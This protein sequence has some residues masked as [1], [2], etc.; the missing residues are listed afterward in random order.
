MTT[1]VKLEKHFSQ[2]KKQ[3]NEK[4]ESLLHHLLKDHV[5][6]VLVHQVETNTRKTPDHC[7]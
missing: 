3:T 7:E 2:K 6:T 1:L 5:V 4:L